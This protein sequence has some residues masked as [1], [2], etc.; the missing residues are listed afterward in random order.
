MYKTSAARE[1]KRCDLEVIIVYKFVF[2]KAKI[3]QNIDIV[4]DE[5]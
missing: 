4:G 5:F 1:K 2:S 3:V